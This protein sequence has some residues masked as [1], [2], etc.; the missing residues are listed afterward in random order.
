MKIDNFLLFYNFLFN[1]SN[2]YFEKIMNF[3]LKFQTW[4]KDVGNRSFKWKFKS[5]KTIDII[6]LWYVISTNDIPGMCL[7]NRWELSSN[8]NGPYSILIMLILFYHLTNAHSLQALLVL[9]YILII[10]IALFFSYT[11]LEGVYF[12][13]S[14]RDF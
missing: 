11:K 5:G 12:I 4:Y 9:G 1:L 10:I 13:I 8:T 2:V 6:Y 14:I 7:T 3:F